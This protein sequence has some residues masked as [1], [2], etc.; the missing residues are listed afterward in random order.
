MF[1]FLLLDVDG[2]TLH[3]KSECTKECESP[4]VHMCHIFLILTLLE[5]SKNA[6]PRY[7]YSPDKKRSKSQKNAAYP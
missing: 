4:F 6:K 7:I 5:Y 1:L 3:Q 2:D